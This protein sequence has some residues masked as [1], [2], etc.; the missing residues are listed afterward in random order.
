VF[1]TKLPDYGLDAPRVVL[2]LSVGAAFALA[3]ALFAVMAGPKWF[4]AP[5][6]KS[7]GLAFFFPGAALGGTASLMIRG[8]RVGKV[9]LRETHLDALALRGDELVLDVGCG[10]GLMLIGAAKRLTT[11]RATGIDLWQTEDQAANSAEATLANARSEGVAEKISLH[12]ADAR[13]LPFAD[14]SFDLV[15]SS[16]ALHNIYD[17]PGRARAIGEIIRVLKPGGRALITDIRH[18]E[19]YAGVF[20]AGGCAVEM[21]GTSHLFLTPSRTLRAT[22]PASH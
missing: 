21:L 13:A 6:A 20:R 12:T 22:K 17:A 14:A 11:G 8:S 4:S 15:L 2:G 5:A 18:A 3:L 1:Q 19:E 16:Y 10:H 9:R 7:V